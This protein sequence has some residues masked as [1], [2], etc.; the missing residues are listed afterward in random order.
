LLADLQWTDGMLAGLA[1]DAPPADGLERVLARID[2]LRPARERRS[3]WLRTAGPCAAAVLAGS[4]A[5]H[6]GGALAALAFFAL[7]SIVTLAIA[8]VL[9]LESQRRSS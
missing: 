6:M 9:I 5:I 8:P 3:H 1:A 2:T 7:G 4:V